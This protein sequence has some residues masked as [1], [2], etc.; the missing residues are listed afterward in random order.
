MGDVM[1][2]AFE[3]ASKPQEVIQKL[4]SMYKPQMDHALLLSRLLDK[5]VRIVAVSANVSP[6]VLG[7]M[8]LIPTESAQ[9]GLDIAMKLSGKENPSVLIFPQAERTLP[10]LK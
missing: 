3:G 4:N 1:I 10:M 7:K 5:G 2:Q 6:E 8:L 9:E